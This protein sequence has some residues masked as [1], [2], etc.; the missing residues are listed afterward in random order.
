[1]VWKIKKNYQL[2]KKQLQKELLEA[3]ESGGEWSDEDIMGQIDALIVSAS[4]MYI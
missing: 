2:L 1:M 4:K 3:L